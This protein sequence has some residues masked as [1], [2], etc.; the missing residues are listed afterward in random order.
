MRFEDILLSPPVTVLLFLAV[1]GMVYWL[2]SRFAPQFVKVGGKT[3]TYSCGEDL[4]ASKIQVS[5]RL[6][7]YVALFFTIM[8]VAVLVVATI[9][10]GSL[11]L[12]GLIYLVMIFLSVLALITRN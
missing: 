6:F 4:P 5:Y 11:A 8:H 9:P 1:F 10:S 3:A 2:G 12:I 7:F